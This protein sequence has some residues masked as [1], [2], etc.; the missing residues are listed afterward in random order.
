MEKQLLEDIAK[1][2][3]RL[4]PELYHLMAAKEITVQSVVD[5]NKKIAALYI[6]VEPNLA[7][8]FW[9]MFG[10]EKNSPSQAS[11]FTRLIAK[12]GINV[13]YDTSFHIFPF[14]KKDNSEF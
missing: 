10:A 2:A 13:L 7:G 12:I 3:Y 14:T 5:S 11:K 4:E 6:G 1:E 9:F 8:T